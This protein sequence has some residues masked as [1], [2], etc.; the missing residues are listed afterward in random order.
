M[1]VHF[2]VA[3]Q[4]EIG[5]ESLWTILHENCFNSFPHDTTGTLCTL[6]IVHSKDSSFWCLSTCLY[7]FHL[8]RNLYSHFMHLTLFKIEWCFWW[9]SSSFHLYCIQNTRHIKGFTFNVNLWMPFQMWLC[10]ECFLAN[11][12]WIDSFPFKFPNVLICVDNSFW[13]YTL[14]DTLHIQ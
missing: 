9:F 7:S 14:C 8:S 11:S 4:F 2:V 1:E 6:W 10:Q 3:S 5:F 12:T 13:T